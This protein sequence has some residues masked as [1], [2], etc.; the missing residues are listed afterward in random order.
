MTHFVEVILPLNLANSFSYR[1]SEREASFIQPGHR[2]TVPFGKTSVYTGI[3][4]ETHKEHPRGYRVKDIEE[5]LDVEPIVTEQQ[6]E[7]W[8]WIADYYMCSLGMV[9][10]ASLPSTLLLESENYLQYNPEVVLDYDDLKPRE[11]ELLA[12]MESKGTLQVRQA[13]RLMQRKSVLKLVARLVD[14]GAISTL[15]VVKEKYKVKVQKYVMLDPHYSDEDNLSN[16]L[17]QLSKGAHKQ[18]D[19][20]MHL[21]TL[22]ARTQG[23]VRSSMLLKEAKAGRG[24]LDKLVQMGVVVEQEIEVDRIAAYGKQ[25]KSV[26]AL[27]KAQSEALEQIEEGFK[28]LKPVLLHGITGSGKTEIYVELIKRTFAKGKSAL[29]LLPEIALTT[30]LIERL[31]VYF[32]DQVLVYHSKMSLQERTEMYYRM[33]NPPGDKPTVLMGARSCVLL[34]IRDLGLIIVDEEHE[35]SYKQFDPAPRYNAR[36]T[37]VVLA[38]QR[39]VPIVLGSATPAI[40]TY[41]AARQ[42]RYKLVELLERFNDAQHPE[43]KLINLKKAHFKKQMKGNLSQE[44]IDAMEREFIQGKQV[45]ILQNRRGFAPLLECNTC[46]NASECPNCDVGLT[47]HK[48]SQHLRCHY[49]GYSIS[50]PI[51]CAVCHST[52]LD[53]KG[54]GTQQIEQEV[55]KLFPDRKIARMD[56]DTTR[57]KHNYQRLITGV[58]RGEIDCLVGTQMLAKGLDFKNVTL[59]GVINAD[60]MLFFPDFRATERSF[61][62]LTQVSGRAGR[63]QD[64]GEVLIQTYNPDHPVLQEV[65]TLDYARMFQREMREREQYAYPPFT[66]MIRVEL[67]HMDYDITKKAADW[68]ATGLR[69]GLSDDVIGPAQPGISRVRNR[70]VWQVVIKLSRKRNQKASK[71]L[72]RR[73]IKSFEAVGMFKKVRQSVDVDAY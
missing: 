69:N 44:L 35:A 9:M 43:V 15:Q 49:C 55:Q 18:R 12:I 14:L 72:I 60:Q 65:K 45:L 2:V 46:G 3:A 47:Y 28:E 20:L 54:V 50:R 8:K 64:L 63:A 38:T 24:S 21:F 4:L 51:Y 17:E 68:I 67:K 31:K 25:P 56:L 57:G 42:G 30:Q 37:A 66:R 62:L 33:L 32:A 11:A 70:F 19:L 26:K 73:L 13:A 22:S 41:H 27:S 48:F 59:V 10:K 36:D 61:Q 71:F 53:A 7:L 6:L 39:K 58:E 40:E 5:I 34:P 52:D 16:L 29:Y 1:I 23:P